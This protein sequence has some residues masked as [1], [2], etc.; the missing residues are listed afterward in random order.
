M[1]SPTNGGGAGGFL[2]LLDL[3]GLD[4][5]SGALEDPELDKGG[6]GALG[7]AHIKFS[8]HSGVG[9][10]ED[11]LSPPSSFAA[12]TAA[13]S[14][15][16]AGGNKT[17]ASANAAEDAILARAFGPPPSTSAFRK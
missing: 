17:Q 16:G 15:S 2:D 4:L 3:K 9:V 12:P 10:G 5:S 1:A 7:E 11:L 13:S 8:Q 6:F 14:S